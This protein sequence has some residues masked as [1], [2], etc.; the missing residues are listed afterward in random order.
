MELRALPVRPVPMSTVSV[1]GD[2]LRE[3]FDTHYG[4]MVRLAA[5]LLGSAASAEDVVQDAFV[6]VDRHLPRIEPA[7]RPAYLRR[8]VINRARSV[9]RRSR[10]LKRQVVVERLVV[11]SEDAAVDDDRRRRVAEA[12]AGL[13]ERQRHCLVLRYYGGMTDREI[14]EHLNLAAGSVKTHL[15]RGRQALQHTLGDLR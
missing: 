5:L 11:E 7:A 2:P 15:Q 10:A 8:A 1:T 3:L 9:T 14:A 12:L 13:P 4:P 6:A